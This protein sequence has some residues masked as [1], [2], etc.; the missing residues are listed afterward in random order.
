M[1]LP[2]LLLLFAALT[3][4]QTNLLTPREI[5]DGWILLYDGSTLFGWTAEGK[6]QWRVGTDGSLI[7]DSGEA[8][9]LRANSPF[10]DFIL[11]CDFRT[12]ETG[13]SG[14]FLRSAKAGAPHVTGYELQIW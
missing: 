5:A 2:A 11:K 7:A 13:N 9:W 8:G 10:A 12:G 4:A 14:I 3:S 6:A 1:R